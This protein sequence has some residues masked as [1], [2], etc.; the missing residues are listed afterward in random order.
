[1]GLLDSLIGP[2]TTLASKFIPDKDLAAKL[3]HELATMSDKMANE[4]MLAQIEVNKAEAASGSLFKGGWRP[5]IGWVCCIA[6]AY[7]FIFQPFL[8]FLFATFGVSIP[9][10]PEFDM[11]TLM[12]VLMGML[13]L[14]GLRT[15][16]KA[17]GISK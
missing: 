14:G 4:Q 9:D 7:L 5:F 10:L 2:A 17:K 6:F 3:G 16:E 8:I 1:M 15:F 13:G 12:P 11:G